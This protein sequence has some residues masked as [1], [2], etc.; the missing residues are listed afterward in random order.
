MTDPNSLSGA[1]LITWWQEACPRER[2]A[3]LL[4][5]LEQWEWECWPSTYDGVLRAA[6]VPPR[7]SEY[8]PTNYPQAVARQCGWEHERFSDWDLSCRHAKSHQPGIPRVSESLDL[9]RSIE[10]RVM[11]LGGEMEWLDAII[12]IAGPRNPEE[13]KPREIVALIRASS[14]DRALACLLALQE[15]KR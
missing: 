8:E 10:E 2:D 3:A 4:I 9:I 12:T 6:L 7:G 11:K 15:V 13:A 1:D 14:S 5:G